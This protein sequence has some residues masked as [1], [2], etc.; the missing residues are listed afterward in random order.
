MITS[1]TAIVFPAGSNK[2]DEHW[3]I[4]SQEPLLPNTPGLTTIRA[5]RMTLPADAQSDAIRAVSYLS[6]CR[7]AL[8]GDTLADSLRE[9]CDYDMP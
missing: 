3:R 5:P 8:G 6:D 7:S 4:L 9:D 2:R 1:I